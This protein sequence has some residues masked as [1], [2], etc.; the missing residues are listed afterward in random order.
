MAE[1]II[2]YEESEKNQVNAALRAL[3]EIGWSY[4]RQ[5]K[6][7]GVGDIAFL[8]EKAPVK[9][10][11]WKCRVTAVDS[12]CSAGSAQYFK[13]DSEGDQAFQIS[14]LYEYPISDELSLEAFRKIGYEGNMQGPFRLFSV[15]ALEKYIHTVDRAYR[16]GE[17]NAVIPQGMP[18]KTLEELA[19]GHSAAAPE[20]YQVREK[21]YVRSP[22]VAALAK[23]RA[24][25]FCDLCKK[26]APFL[27]PYGQPYLEVHHIRPLAEGGADDKKNVA[28]LCP[29]CHRKMHSLKDIQDSKAL[30]ARA[31]KE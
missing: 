23:R 10:I 28:A 18:M 6:S 21:R 17:R 26:P 4:T 5:T 16:T 13:E 8:Y 12:A 25:G 19:A 27:D 11:R 30:I 14:P 24:N 3:S 29:N 20:Q 15:P 1:W 7:I 9:A 22:Y 31:G 2:S